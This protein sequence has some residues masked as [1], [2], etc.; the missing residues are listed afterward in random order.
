MTQMNLG[1]A[2]QRLGEREGGTARLEEAVAVYRD[3]LQE[4][5]RA[6]VPLEWAGTQM[7]L[8]NAL[9]TLGEREG[10][11]RG[12]KRRFPPFL[13]LNILNCL[14]F[15]SDTADEVLQKNLLCDK[16]RGGLTRSMADKLPWLW[17]Q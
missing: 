14:R 15:P 11:R 3:A 12:W 4:N 5:I 8:G 17:V 16:A 9:E 10:A 13:C 6:R 7:N 2:L 1:N